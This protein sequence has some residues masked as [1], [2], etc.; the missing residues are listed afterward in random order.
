MQ[1]R[2]RNR[3]KDKLDQLWHEGITRIERWEMV[4]MFGKERVTVADWRIV[5]EAWAEMFEKP[6]KADALALMK[7]QNTTGQLPIAYVLLI[8]SGVKPLPL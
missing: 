4:S 3:L 2:H 8:K 1:Q 6:E 7:V 5:Q